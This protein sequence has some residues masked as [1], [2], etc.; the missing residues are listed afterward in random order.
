LVIIDPTQVNSTSLSQVR[1]TKI[2]YLDLGELA[3]MSLGSCF[4]SSNV[5]LGYDTQWNQSIVNVSSP[6]WES[7]I[8][9]QVRYVMSTGFQGVMFDDV[10]V[11]EQ[12][13]Q[14]ERGIISVIHWVREEYPNAIMGVNRG[15]QVLPNVSHL[16]NFVLFEDYG[17]RVVSP[18]NV[19]F[20]NFTQ[21][22]NLTAYVRSYNVTVLAMGY[23]L[24]PYDVYYNMVKDLAQEESV[25]SFVTNW[26]VCAIWQQ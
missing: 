5:T 17:T 21:V 26:N 20:A 11:A 2:A 8:E 4:L 6:A 7:Y 24:H 1:A 13:L 14:T 15:F 16:I 10:D 25:P 23:A 18:N 3:N 22:E 9:C 12:Y 19:S